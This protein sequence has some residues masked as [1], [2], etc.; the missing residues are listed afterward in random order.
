MFIPTEISANVL[1]RR[2]CKRGALEPFIIE[3]R[4][5]TKSL[6]FD[7]K[8]LLHNNRFFLFDNMS[9]VWRGFVPIG[10]VY[11]IYTGV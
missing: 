1:Q 2:S 4:Q 7:L 10:D 8:P 5:I 9:Y 6:F 3:Q 11:N